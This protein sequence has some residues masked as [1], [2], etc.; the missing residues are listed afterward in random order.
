LV[1]LN[2]TQLILP[3]IVQIHRNRGTADYLDGDPSKAVDSLL[4]FGLPIEDLIETA[5]MVRRLKT[6]ASVRAMPVPGLI[7][8]FGK[9]APE[10]KRLGWLPK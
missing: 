3:R 10:F 7:G 2:G 8:P 9:T 4:G 1:I 6:Q 5:S